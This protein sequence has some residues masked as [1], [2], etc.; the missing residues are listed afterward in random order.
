[1]DKNQYLKQK[2]QQVLDLIS[3]SKILKRHNIKVDYVIRTDREVLVLELPN[4]KQWNIECTFN[5]I[6]WIEVELL[7]ALITYIKGE[8]LDIRTLE[9][10]TQHWSI[11]SLDTYHWLSSL[12]QK[13]T[14]K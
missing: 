13:W 9:K 6:D 12:K 4:N 7:Q 3:N 5:S 14:K 2:R 11:E 10:Y 1:M 8:S